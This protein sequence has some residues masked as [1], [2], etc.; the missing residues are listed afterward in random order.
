MQ[1]RHTRQR[2]GLSLAGLFMLATAGTPA[3][4]PERILLIGNSYTAATWQAL[5]SFVQADLQLQGSTV[6]AVCPGGRKLVEHLR[7]AAT[8]SLVET[9]RWSCVVLQEQSVLP[10]LAARNAAAR[11]DFEAG[12]DGLAQLAGRTGAKVLFFQTWARA[13]G[14]TNVLA[15]FGGDPGKMMNALAGS[16]QAAA[17]RAPARVAPVGR[18]WERWLAT[19]PDVKL[20]APDRSH[21]NATG[22]YLTGAV[23]YVTL[24]GHA[25]GGLP[26]TASL[27]PT[28]AAALRA[29][30]D[31]LAAAP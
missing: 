10:A 8:V 21:P 12:A 19:H 25:C 2:L 4:A 9:G 1:A 20:H 3:A 28:T 18:A 5:R 7:D 16:Y 11:Q 30:A 31:E 26:Y 17:E 29:L 22:A 27:P 15:A 13:A 14:E 23:I 24:T 6:T